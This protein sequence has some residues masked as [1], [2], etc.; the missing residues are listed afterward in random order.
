[1]VYSRALLVDNLYPSESRIVVWCEV[2]QHVCC[3]SDGVTVPVVG[4]VVE[5]HAELYLVWLIVANYLWKYIKIGG[6]NVTSFFS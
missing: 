4:E 2:L 1:M 5:M 3:L 6:M